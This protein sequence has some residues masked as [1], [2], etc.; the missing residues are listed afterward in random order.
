MNTPIAGIIGANMISEMGPSWLLDTNTVSETMRPF[1]APRVAA[2]LDSI[3]GEGICLS[4]ISAWE[5]LNGIRRL[6]PGRRRQDL[7]ERFGRLLDDLFKDRIVD[8]T[9][10]DARICADLM[11]EKRRCG[12]PLDD[13]L[14][15]AMIAATAIRRRLIVITRNTRE[16][17]NI[18]ID[19]FNP[20]IDPPPSR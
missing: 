6:D 4:S 1:P 16:F 9:L 10:T 17:N 3:A 13:R 8:W 2:F 19:I 5:I 11:E 20:R 18:G 14:P 12:E 15:D 7:A